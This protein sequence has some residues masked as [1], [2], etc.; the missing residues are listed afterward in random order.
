MHGQRKLRLY[1]SMAGVAELRLWRFQQA[2]AEPAHLIRSGDNLEELSLG[3]REFALAWIL[4]LTDEV[5]RM[6]GIAGNALRRMFGVIESLLQFPGDMAGLAAIR[7][8]L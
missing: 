6:T 3:S 2:V 8:F 4:V 7:I 1:R 5:R